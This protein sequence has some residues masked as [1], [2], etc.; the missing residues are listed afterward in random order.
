MGAT[1]PA[2]MVFGAMSIMLLVGV[3]LRAKIG[4]IQKAMIP[5]SLIGGVIGFVLVTLG[6]LKF[7]GPDGVWITIK[8]TDFIP[9]AFHAF[10]ISF[11]SLCLTRTVNTGRKSSVLKGGLWLSMMWSASLTVQA[12]VGAG[13]VSVYNMVTGGDVNTFLGYLVTHGFTQGPGQG[14]AMGGAWAK[15]FQVPDGPTMGLIWATMGFVAA[16]VVGVP[17]A[18]YFVKNGMNINKR[19]KVD[20][21][22]LSGILKPET[23]LEAGRETTHSATTETFAYHLAIIGLVYVITYVEIT[24]VSK[25]VKHLLFSYPLF[26]FHGL[27]WAS[28]L[29]II[30]EKIGVGRLMDPGIQKRI[31]GMSVDFL[32]VASV[33]GVSFVVLTKYIGVII[34]V[35]IAVTIVTFLL[36]EFF[37]RRVSELGPERAVSSFGCCCGSTASGL[38]LLR[39]LDAD[40]SSGVGMELAFFNVAIL[41][42]TLPILTIMAPQLPG[43]GATTIIGAYA[44]YSLVCFGILWFLGSWRKTAA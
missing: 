44:L 9:F 35:T 41:F 28:V 43:Y 34:A 22:F 11:I 26:F 6:W 15:G 1:L 38:L 8:S 5:S 4:F 36:I 30:M 2:F 19:S 25:Y 20:E 23:H 37:R 12:L 17:Y 32:L 31:T 7:P 10:N 33:M 16:Y 40:Y 21:E 3:F 42:T 13:T 27:V 18:R 39:I 24:F 29:R 14:L